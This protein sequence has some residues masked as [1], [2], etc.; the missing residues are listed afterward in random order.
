[1]KDKIIAELRV[2]YPG[3][4]SSKFMDSLAD[5]LAAK[6][7]KEEDIQGA[8][9]ELDNSLIRVLDIQAEG[10]RRA[11]ELQKTIS[12]MKAELNKKV[13]T[14]PPDT[15]AAVQALQERLNQ[16]EQEKQNE[17]IHY[18]LMEAGRERKIPKVLLESATAKTAEE[19]DSVIQAL[20]AKAV[21]LRKELGVEIGTDPPR[22]ATG[23]A[24][25]KEQVTDDIKQFSKN[26][27]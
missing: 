27:K 5:R 3:Q 23:P 21:E 9:G 11:T 16:L 8:V 15:A 14:P 4:L 22:K 2:K 12:E 24:T 6:V 26:I 18:K 1:M 10:D 7:E 19:V 13:D 25:T 17:A 20:E